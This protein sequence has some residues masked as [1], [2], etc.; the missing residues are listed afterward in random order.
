MRVS[1]RLAAVLVA[2]LAAASPA[3]TQSTP[4]DN[5][6]NHQV[7]NGD[8]LWGIAAQYG[9]NVDELVKLN[10]LTFPDLI[11]PG[12]VIRTPARQSSPPPGGEYQ[13]QP[14]D[15]LSHIAV[16]FGVELEALREANELTNID[17]IIPG[18][19]LRI[20]GA[21][22][23]AVAPPEPVRHPPQNSELDALFAELAAAEGLNPGL[24]KAISWL[25]SGWQQEVVSPAGAV[26][27]MQVTPVTAE[28]LEKAVLGEQLNEDVSI[29]DN[30]KMGARYLRVL[31]D[32]TGD[33]ETAIASYYQGYGTTLSGKMYEE[34]K[35]YVRLVRAIQERYWP[36]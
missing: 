1:W 10:E 16:R 27:F 30:V 32:V 33:E 25:E 19:R 11:L 29:Y 23:P 24:V 6:Q 35:Q 2:M 20:P 9:A 26:G 31:L 4:A 17:L 18:Q 28:W 8:T 36:D 14:G 21:P 13:V 22:T 15:T 12:D 3:A 5:T 7:V 34:T